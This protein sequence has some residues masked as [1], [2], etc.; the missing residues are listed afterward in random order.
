MEKTETQAI[1]LGIHTFTFSDKTVRKTVLINVRRGLGI[2]KDNF[3]IDALVQKIQAIADKHFANLANCENPELSKINA[4]GIFYH[5]KGQPDSESFQ[6]HEDVDAMG[7]WLELIGRIRNALPEGYG[8]FPDTLSLISTDSNSED[9]FT[10][11][12]LDSADFDSDFS[13]CLESSSDSWKP[14]PFD[15]E[16]SEDFLDSDNPLSLENLPLPNPEASSDEESLHSEGEAVMTSSRSSSK[17]SRTNFF[18]SRSSN[19]RGFLDPEDYPLGPRR[20]SQDM[21]CRFDSKAAEKAEKQDQEAETEPLL[22]PAEVTNPYCRS[23]RDIAKD[24]YRRIR[25]TSRA[26]VPKKRT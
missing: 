15:D 4:R 22:P 14:M 19:S 3:Q 16:R 21:M 26:K 1:N 11:S 25:S 18:L 2:S 10:E 9:P 5:S 23:H 17:S 8:A 6:S 24:Q 13:L 12:D 20:Y 7:D